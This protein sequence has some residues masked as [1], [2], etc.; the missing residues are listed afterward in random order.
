MQPTLH[1]SAERYRQIFTYSNDAI[2]VIDP[3]QDQIIE[4]NPRACAML[5]YSR[6]ELL[7]TPISGVHPNEMSR[8]LAFAMTVLNDGHGWTNELSCLTKNGQFLPAE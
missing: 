7:T 5:G 2:F 6:E 1:D 4:A 3:A 8:M